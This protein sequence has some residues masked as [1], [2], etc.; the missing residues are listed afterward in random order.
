MQQGVFFVFYEIGIAGI[1]KVIGI[2]P[3]HIK[4]RALGAYNAYP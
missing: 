1:T 4:L 3:Q 2:C